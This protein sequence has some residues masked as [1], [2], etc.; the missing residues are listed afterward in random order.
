[1]SG[2]W[3]QTPPPV[4]DETSGNDVGGGVAP[5]DELVEVGDVTG[6]G[7]VLLGGR[8]LGAVLAGAWRNST[9]PCSAG[10]TKAPG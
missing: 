2:R 1:M 3:N 6:L 7:G 9:E 5:G 4:G 10:R 8:L